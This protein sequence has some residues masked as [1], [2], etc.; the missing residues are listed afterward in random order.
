MNFFYRLPLLTFSHFLLSSAQYSGDNTCDFRNICQNRYLDQ[1]PNFIRDA[2]D[3]FNMPS[4]SIFID[5]FMEKKTLLPNIDYIACLVNTCDDHVKVA[6]FLFQKTA[7][8]RPY[9]V[10]QTFRGSKEEKNRFGKVR[11]EVFQ[12]MNIV[13]TTRQRERFEIR[14]TKMPK[15]FK[16]WNGQVQRVLKP[17][18]E[19]LNGWEND[20][21]TIDKRTFNNQNFMLDQMVYNILRHQ[22]GDYENISRDTRSSFIEKLEEKLQCRIRVVKRQL[23]NQ[24]NDQNGSEK[25]LLNEFKV[26]YSQCEGRSESCT[27]ENRVKVFIAKYMFN[28]RDQLNDIFF[29]KVCS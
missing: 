15:S 2:A 21:G 14:L 9:S 10:P 19:I 22:I 17:Y 12:L 26:N 25:E 24:R 13:M 11:I 4:Y 7:R 8:E 20:F 18:L 3:N 23:N 1:F 16:H 6:R 27:L 5:T 28:N 29:N